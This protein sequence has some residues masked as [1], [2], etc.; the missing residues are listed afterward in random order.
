MGSRLLTSA[1]QS[2]QRHMGS[3][4]GQAMLRMHQR[5]LSKM[6]DEE[7]FQRLIREQEEVQLKDHCFVGGVT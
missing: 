4:L 3:A 6:V 7:A 1:L 2:T 5:G